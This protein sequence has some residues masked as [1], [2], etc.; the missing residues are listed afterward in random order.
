M[1]NDVKGLLGDE[2]ARKLE[3]MARIINR[4]MDIYDEH[5]ETCQVLIDIMSDAD[6]KVSRDQLSKIIDRIRDLLRDVNETAISQFVQ[7]ARKIGKVYDQTFDYYNTFRLEWN[8][9]V[10]R[11]KRVADSN[12]IELDTFLLYAPEL[13]V[14]AVKH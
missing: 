7:N 6:T 1:H 12:G 5:A 3:E 4:N 9:E 11:L 8:D 10:T 14:V 2:E 13:G